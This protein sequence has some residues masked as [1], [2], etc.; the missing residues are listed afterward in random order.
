M[1][2]KPDDSR[3]KNNLKRGQLTILWPDAYKTIKQHTAFGF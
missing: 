2:H 1:V 3:N